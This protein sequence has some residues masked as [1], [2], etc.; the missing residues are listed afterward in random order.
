M[1]HRNDIY[2][3]LKVCTTGKIN[4]NSSID[5]ELSV[6]RYLKSIEADHPGKGFLRLA[7]DDFQLP[8]PNGDHQCLL[9]TPL[10]LNYTKLRS[11]FPE[12]CIP[13]HLVQYSLQI[14]LVGLDFIH[15]TGVVHTGQFSS[16]MLSKRSS[17]FWTELECRSVA[18]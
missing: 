9:F 18:E 14:L 8:G 17:V 3:A 7:V 13:K 1:I 6:S 12:N 2:L 11:L 15:Q 5:N 4:H 10:G 16:C